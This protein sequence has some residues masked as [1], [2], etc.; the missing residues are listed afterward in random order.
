MAAGTERKSLELLQ[1]LR[2]HT[3]TC[4]DTMLLGWRG[5]ILET[6]ALFARCHFKRF[7][8]SEHPKTPLRKH[9]QTFRTFKREVVLS[10]P[11]FTQC[12]KRLRSLCYCVLINDRLHYS[13][14]RSKLV[15][16]MHHLA[17]GG[18]INKVTSK[19]QKQIIFSFL[20]FLLLQWYD[21]THSLA[22]LRLQ[23]LT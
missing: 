20:F 3:Q 12:L 11:S 16:A 8:Y 17:S 6:Q 19:S 4:C 1:T 18:V 2:R 13:T 5:I 23:F 7:L 9:I 14:F 10:A 22:D 15:V 21:R